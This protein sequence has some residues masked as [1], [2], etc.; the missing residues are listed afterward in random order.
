MDG[1]AFHVGPES[2]DRMAN[3]RFAVTVACRNFATLRR[4]IRM[5]LIRT[6]T[7]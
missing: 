2:C 4:T 3:D 5:A 7:N 6:D 1:F